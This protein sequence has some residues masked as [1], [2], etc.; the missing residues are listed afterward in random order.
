MTSDAA[1]H[2]AVT[3][4]PIHGVPGAPCSCAAS[5]AM[6]DAFWIAS[7]MCSGKNEPT[8]KGTNRRPRTTLIAAAV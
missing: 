5:P 7:P 6:G 2:A 8:L 3:P 1:A 4:N